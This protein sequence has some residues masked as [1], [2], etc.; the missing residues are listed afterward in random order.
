VRLKLLDYTYFLNLESNLNEQKTVKNNFS[1]LSHFYQYFNE[2][3]VFHMKINPNSTSSGENSIFTKTTS[4][5]AVPFIF[6]NA[7]DLCDERDL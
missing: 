3:L 4:P 1:N 7:V 2:F 5:L 6:I